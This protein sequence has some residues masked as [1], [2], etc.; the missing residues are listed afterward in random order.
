M[1][2][3]ED[4]LKRL[5]SSNDLDPEIIDELYDVL[6]ELGWVEQ[7]FK[8]QFKLLKGKVEEIIDLL[9]DNNVIHRWIFK[10]QGL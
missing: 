5:I 3:E 8:A 7:M 2:S 4:I 9:K 10:K 6:K 1:L